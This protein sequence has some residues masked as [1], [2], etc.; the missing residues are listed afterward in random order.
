M[1]KNLAFYSEFDSFYDYGVNSHSVA[2]FK[3][4]A[5]RKRMLTPE[6]KRKLLVLAPEH[7]SR[8]GF[9]IRLFP[10]GEMTG[11]QFLTGSQFKVVPPVRCGALFTE[12]FTS[13]ARVKIRRSVECSKT[14]LNKFCTL[15][16]SPAH[17]RLEHNDWLSGV[18]VPRTEFPPLNDDGTVNHKW[19]KWKLKKFLHAASVQQARRQSQLNYVWVAELQTESTGNIHFHILWDKFFKIEWLT[20]IWGQASNSVDIRKLNDPLHASRYM[21]KYLTKDEKS[22]IQGNRYFISKGLRETMIPEEKIIF[23][24][25]HQESQLIP[26]GYKPCDLIRDRLQD[27]KYDV[28][29]HGGK[30]L[31]FGFSIP[32]PRRMKR[33]KNKYGHEQWS[34]GVHGRLAPAL[35]SYLTEVAD[36]ASLLVVPF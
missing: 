2:F 1:K 30:V 4:L 11:G 14:F 21:R 16:F 23:E 29:R 3:K 26:A 22:A 31:D 24:M 17:V 12:G 5:E 34:R 15:T 20:K 8:V 18:S 9:K 7:S 28:E 33:F 19:A 6:D 10:S 35:A 27:L 32:M 13:A 25:D 36:R